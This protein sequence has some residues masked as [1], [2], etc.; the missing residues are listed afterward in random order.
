MARGARGDQ[1]RQRTRA[2]AD[3]AGQPGGRR[4]SHRCPRSCSSSARPGSTRSAGCWRKS[5]STKRPRP[6]VPRPRPCSGPPPCRCRVCSSPSS[7]RCARCKLQ[8]LDPAVTAPSAV[9]GHSQGLARRGGRQGQG[10]RRTR[11]CSRSR[12]CSVPPRSLVARRRGLMAVGDRSPMLAVSNVDRAQLEAAVAEIASRA[13]T[14]TPRRSSRIRNGRRRF[15]ISGPPAAA[16]AR[17][18][19]LRADRR[20]AD[21]RAG[22]QEA[23]RRRVLARRSSRWR[24]RSASTTRRS[25]RPSTSSA[26]GPRCAASTSNSRAPRCGRARRS[27]RLGRGR[28]RRRRRRCRLDPRRRPGRPAHPHDG[29]RRCAATGVGIVAAATRGGHRNLLTPGAAPRGQ[30]PRGPT[31]APTVVTLPDGTHRTSRPPSPG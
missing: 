25:P 15:V 13:P 4:F 20:R 10:P 21:P 5:S 23:W 2:R 17:Q 9:I 14:P 29:G 19:A 3:R 12:S 11:S 1:P 31:F 30:P 27:R 26:T 16:R 7:P 28:R 8:G 6:P 22:R 24:S 18:G